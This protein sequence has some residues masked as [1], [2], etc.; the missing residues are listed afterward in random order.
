MQ[1]ITKLL[2]KQT[3]ITLENLSAAVEQCDINNVTDGIE[4]SRWLFHA[5][6]SLD[7]WF[8]NPLVY[9]APHGIDLSAAKLFDT[10]GGEPVTREL[11]RDF[12]NKAA[13]KTLAYLEKL[14]DEE[15]YEKPP[16]CE[17][18]RIELILGQTRHIMCHVGIIMGADLKQNGTCSDY[19]GLDRK[20]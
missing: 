6:A 19:Y 14:T 1:M 3:E 10:Y 9:E 13:E 7:R 15:L 4:N 2:K 5:I 12:M 20:Y 17:Y 18:T 16:R 11:L 8:I